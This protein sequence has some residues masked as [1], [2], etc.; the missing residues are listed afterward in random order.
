MIIYFIPPIFIFLAAFL[1]KVAEEKK[2][3][4]YKDKFFLIK[5]ALFF[6]AL[7]VGLRGIS[8]GTDTHTYEWLYGRYGSLNFAEILELGGL[9]EIGYRMSISV[10][11]K[12]GLSFNMS[13]VIFSCFIFA[14]LYFLLKKNSVK[15]EASLLIY[16][17]FDFYILNFSMLRQ[18]I[19]MAIYMLYFVWR[20]NDKWDLIKFLMCVAIA[21]SF[22][23]V[24][25]VFV[26]AFV[27][28]KV[29]Y[30]KIYMQ[31][32]LCAGMVTFL[33][34]DV[35]VRIV[36]SVAGNMDENYATYEYTGGNYYGM[37]LYLLLLIIILFIWLFSS[38]EALKK[39]AEFLYIV[40]GGIIVFPV[41]MSG[42]VILRVIYYYLIF[43]IVLFPNAISMMKDLLGK[44][45]GYIAIYGIGLLYYV[46]SVANNT[47][48]IL[49]YQF[50]WQI[51]NMDK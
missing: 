22:H 9:K 15:P 30:K 19:A 3:I 34:K 45:V 8:V 29:P 36:A 39:N 27:L 44:C 33:L 1:N 51:S 5:I 14:A 21:V 43:M 20:K 12:L 41:V 35:L 24:A 7:S 25:I 46:N 48:S 6:M 37:K 38:K 49:P 26:P 4:L 18:S 50:F 23:K 10:M 40:M 32:L 28:A 2:I 16:I 31:I 47:L 42:G 13:N 17:F 11:Y